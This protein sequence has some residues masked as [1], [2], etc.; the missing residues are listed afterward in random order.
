MMGDEWRKVGIRE[1]LSVA[2]IAPKPAAVNG[3]DFKGPCYG[4]SGRRRETGL[5]KKRPRA[6]GGA[7]ERCAKLQSVAV[8]V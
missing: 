7:E 5:E 4:S 1:P 8:G 6:G 2:V 3:S